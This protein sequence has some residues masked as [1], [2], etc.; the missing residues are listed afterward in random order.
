MTKTDLMLVGLQA[1][2]L[3]MTGET[4]RSAASRLQ[5]SGEGLANEE[6]VD[7]LNAAANAINDLSLLAKD[8]YDEVAKN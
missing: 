8:L 5:K 7:Y 6:A 1:L 3:T 2:V 4:L